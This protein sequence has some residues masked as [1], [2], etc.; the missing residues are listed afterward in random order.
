VIFA[1]GA[2]QMHQAARLMFSGLLRRA[3][4]FPQDLGEVVPVVDRQLRPISYWLDLIGSSG[5]A[6]NKALVDWL[7]AEYGVGHGHATALVGYAL[8]HRDG[9]VPEPGKDQ[10]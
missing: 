4:G 1:A 8:A 2:D 5:L 10:A 3:V 9:T 7:K 6:K